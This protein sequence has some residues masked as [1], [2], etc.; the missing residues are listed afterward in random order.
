MGFFTEA[1]HF[2]SST[3]RLAPAMA[4]VAT[5]APAL[6]W[7]AAPYD[8]AATA[9][10][11]RTVLPT[12]TFE[13][14]S[15][16]LDCSKK[17]EEASGA[18]RVYQGNLA[19]QFNP[20]RSMSNPDAEWI[21]GWDSLPTDDGPSKA[22]LVFKAIALARVSRT[23]SERCDGAFA[24]AKERLDALEKSTR[25]GI[26]AAQAQPNVYSRISALLA[27]REK[28]AATKNPLDRY[29]GP[30][31]EL[32]LAI[33]EAFR[34]TGRDYVYFL[35][36][37]G[38]SGEELGRLRARKDEA[39]ERDAFCFLARKQGSEEVPNGPGVDSYF[40]PAAKYVR[41]LFTPERTQE[42]EKTL[43][44]LRQEA[45]SPFQFKGSLGDP[46]SS[47]SPSSV[48]VEGHPGLVRYEDR[49][50]Q[51]KSVKASGK[52]TLVELAGVLKTS[53]PY[54]C[55]QTKQVESIQQ[56]G[57]VV[58]AKRCKSGELTIDTTTL[59]SF[60][61]L[62]EGLTL[63]PGDQLELY[64]IHKD[65]KLETPV[66]GK[67]RIKEVHRFTLEGKHLLRV[68]RG[69]QPIATYF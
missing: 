9:E 57:T 46:I 52:G 41:P 40:A 69:G 8:E 23:W 28:F 17:L 31:L 37:L 13:S 63:Q 45:A 14:C 25:E 49:N 3:R 61:E 38:P 16:G 10:K 43:T 65:R 1:K 39:F 11:L 42:L 34:T 33:L 55:V 20:R 7:S 44:A 29:V 68:T 36:K 67:N 2:C 26:T 56:D 32:E 51:V 30:R 22:N 60:E 12:F 50:V 64:A 35:H 27:L 54:D 6:A 47:G 66:K 24:A 21:P 59:V 4:L 18:E 15:D 48:V 5:L 53:F 19:Y 62:P 58:Y